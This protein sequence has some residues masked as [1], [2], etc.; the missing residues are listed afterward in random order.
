MEW[1]G[2]PIVGRGVVERRFDVAV[3]DQTVPG[4]LWTPEDAHAPR[5]L[6]LLG[7]GGSQHKRAPNILALARRIVRHLGFAA[8]AIDGPMHGDRIEGG[9][10]QTL[11]DMS[12]RLAE[13]TPEE[14]RA[15]F[16]GAREEWKASLDAL[17]T[18]D[19]VGEGPVGYWGLSM[20]T[21]IGL[22]FVASEPRIDCAVLGLMG[23]AADAR[24]ESAK[25]IHIPVLFLVQWDD[26]LVPRDS[27]L[28]LFDALATKDKAMHVNPG[29]HV[30]VPGEE[31]S[32]SERFFE[33]H[34]GAKLL[35]SE[36]KTM[37]RSSSA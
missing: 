2:E 17:Q 6:V 25:S 1:V 36:D 29:I 16:R 27:A 9:H 34:L 4:I 7:H 15:I 20:G 3:N 18:V 19:G 12:R 24:A 14:A 31:V 10:D 37:T 26:E 5:P 21:V 28:T 35:Q 30:A 22:P 8:A 33:R 32:A 11:E 23:V 13:R